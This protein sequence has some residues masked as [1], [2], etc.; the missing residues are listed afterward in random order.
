MV[1]QGPGL[2]APQVVRHDLMAH[3]GH[4]IGVD[5]DDTAAA[6]AHEGDGDVV[7]AGVQGEVRSD[8]VGDLHGVGHIAAG[9]LDAG[10]V[11][12]GRQAL[13][14]GDG[15]GAAGAAGDII[16]QAGDVHRVRRGGK[17]AV[18]ALRIGLVVI[19]GNEQQGVGPH[20]LVLDTLFHLGGGAVGAAA[21]DDRHPAVHH[22]DGVGHYGGILLVGHGGVFAG[23]TQRQNGVGTGGD[24]ALQQIGQNLEVH[25]AVLMERSDHG[26]NGSLQMFEFHVECPPYFSF[27]R[28]P[29]EAGK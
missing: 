16:E 2:V 6:D 26:H 9:L 3:A 5:G 22:L 1:C 23:G 19:R 17:V 12:V 15:N 7:I 10:D 8:A 20:V 27:F 13:H 29:E 21:H 18:H 11:G 14:Y 4:N 28:R 24:L 25:A